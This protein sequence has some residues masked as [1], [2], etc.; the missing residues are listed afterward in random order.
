MCQA[1][2][3]GVWLQQLLTELGYLKGNETIKI[4]ADNKSAI[5][6]GKNPEFHKR[7]KHIDVQYITTCRNRCEY[8]VCPNLNA[9]R[10]TI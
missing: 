1:I 5:A 10:I 9:G 2:K 6:L 4:H 8:I 7:S 3:E